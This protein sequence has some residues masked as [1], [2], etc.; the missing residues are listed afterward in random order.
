MAPYPDWQNQP[1]IPYAGMDG[2]GTLEPGPTLVV[3]NTGQQE[4]VVNPQGMVGNQHVSDMF[5]GPGA[6][7]NPFATFNPSNALGIGSSAQA[8]N[9]PDGT[10]YGG[11][12]PATAPG[13][14]Q[15]PT[16]GGLMG[17]ATS[18]ASMAADAFAPGS[19]AAV[20]I[21]AQVAQ[22]AIKLGGQLAGVGVQGLMETFLPTGASELAN[23]NWLTR[24]GGA[25]AGVGPQ[26]PNLAGKAPT[27]VPNEQPQ[28]LAGFPQPVQQTTNNNTGG[29]TIVNNLYG[30]GDVKD[31]TMNSFNTDLIRGNAAAMSGSM[32]QKAPGR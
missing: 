31:T 26:L 14:G 8:G 5:P 18:A 16:G 19:G 7:N 9:K 21:G 32:P 23:N 3:N 28:T 6:G 10:Q 30:V 25:F 22:R 2:G 24:I 29:T 12:E 27:P 13:G 4:H 1:T 17:L 11:A 15:A 20:Q